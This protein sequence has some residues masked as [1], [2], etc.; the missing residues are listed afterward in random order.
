MK[1]RWSQGPYEKQSISDSTISGNVFQISGTDGDVSI[2]VD[3]PPADLTT[4]GNIS[5]APPTDHL[6]RPIH[7]RHELLDELLRSL[8]GK[9][10]D[11]VKVLHGLGGCGKSTIAMLLSDQATRQGMDV[12]WISAASRNMLH[13][14]MRQL[15]GA[16]GAPQRR[17]TRAWSGQE[18]AT[19]LLWELLN[20]H[21]RKWLII[22]DGADDPSILAA[23]N[24]PLSD[25]NGW[26]RPPVQSKGS[27]VVTTR[28]NNARRWAPWCSLQPV[29]MLSPADS[30]TVLMDYAGGMAGSRP[31]AEKLATRLGCLPLAL[32][33][34]GT[35]IEATA[36]A[37]WPDSIT[38]Y[39]GY[40]RALETEI[41]ELFPELDADS[42]T[43]GDRQA[44]ELVG[45]TWE[46]SLSAL[47]KRGIT[48]ARPLIQ[49]LSHFADSPIP[50]D[51][52][53][54]QVLDH[55]GVFEGPTKRSLR[56]S[57]EALSDLGLIDIRI[58]QHS[59]SNEKEAQVASIA[60]HP[61]VRDVG[62]YP[63]RLQKPRSIYIAAA[64][65]MVANGT[66]KA[67]QDD[68][69]SW[70]T[71]EALSNHAFYLLS[72]ALEETDGR[73]EV[74]DAAAF[75]AYQSARFLMSRGEFERAH[76]EQI[77]V[78]KALHRIGNEE[79]PNSLTVRHDLAVSL[80]RL[81]RLPEAELELRTVQERKSEIFGPTAP[82]TL[83]TIH[84]H[85]DVLWQLGE[86]TRAENEYRSIL[87]VKDRA[88]S[89]R[90]LLGTRNNLYQV[91]IEQGKLS[92][93]VAEIDGF[94]HDAETKNAGDTTIYQARF[95][96]ARIRKAQARFD[97]AISE[98]REVANY[99]S[100]TLGE[101]HP[102]TL[103][104]RHE[105]GVTLQEGGDAAA[106]CGV[107]RSVYLA[108]SKTQGSDHPETLAT[109]HQFALALQDAGE[110]EEAQAH[111][112]ATL[113]HR[114]KV[115]GE[116]H[117]HTLATRFQ[118]AVL[119]EESGDLENAEEEF[120]NVLIDECATVGADHP[121]TLTT[122]LRLVNYMVLRQQWAKAFEE[123]DRILSARRRIYGIDHP[124]PRDTEQLIAFLKANS[125]D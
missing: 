45:C 64:T 96:R 97:E 109:R 67:P 103:S 81:G 84:A 93:A 26:I 54:L 102:I 114:S 76:I 124:I 21:E 73:A 20:R 32:R 106:A 44:R 46:L 41:S 80:G 42:S 119:L 18:S 59:R 98:F 13:D 16:L 25:G 69:T 101:N 99:H 122:R 43:F 57:V 61:L 108:R 56:A 71:W 38:S 63:R 50:V 37:P 79:H 8:E 70:P 123:L 35:H 60:I 3:S 28:E 87:S 78:L 65:V 100:A 88:P 39:L 29:N 1:W 66:S 12:W 117:L 22:I 110:R 113:K 17:L 91:L 94:V 33:L 7:G 58:P 55:F 27:I 92:Q 118:L 19:D 82:E 90:N 125:P 34:A 48:Q 121:S 74:I 15:S 40:L 104:T 11:G 31:D 36:K 116:R 86:L 120:L 68:W 14:G 107:L 115:L 75:S 83:S 2:N 111:Y 4:P 77:R 53:E 85:A 51:L 89:Y 112:R 6:G 10:A 23:D 52:L 62:R 9:N 24:T 47:E 105:L 72:E 49:M 30:A 95:V 5:I